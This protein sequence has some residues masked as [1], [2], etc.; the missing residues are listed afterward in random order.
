MQFKHPELLYALFLLLIPIIVHL[1]Q[2]RKFKKIEFTNVAFLKEA[3]LQTRKSSRIKK[4]LI[5]SIRL[6][7]LTTLVIAFAQPY[8]SNSDAFNVEKETVVYLDN[9]FSM[10]AKG[11]QGELLKRAVQDLINNIPSEETF[12]LITNDDT[13]KN[14]T[15]EAIKNDLLKLEYSSTKLNHEAALLKSQALFSKKEGV[16][17]NL[18]FISDFQEDASELSANS[19]Q[20]SNIHFVQLVTAETNNIS[21][22]SV[23]ISSTSPTSITLNV[24]LSNSGSPLENLPVSLFNRETLIAKTSVAINETAETSFSIPSN[25]AIDGQISIEDSNL[26]F[27]NSLYFN[28]NR[29]AKI[30][31]LSIN[32]A[33]DSFL[34][35]IYTSSEFDYLATSKNQLD[36][37][38]LE[39]QNLIVLNELENIPTALSITLTQFLKLGGSLL[40]IP[41]SSLNKDSYNVL[42]SPYGCEIIEEITT[43]KLV[44]NI[45][46]AHPLYNK[47]VFE[48]QVNNFQYPRTNKYY[49]LRSSRFSNTL[50]FEDGNAFLTSYKHV[51][52]FTS[53]LNN[54]NSNFKNSP[55]IVPTLYNIGRNSYKIP[56]IYY[57]IG[58]ANTFEVEAQMKQDAVLSLNKGAISIIP[59]QQY[60]NSKV[61]ISSIE[62]PSKAGTYAV[63][64]NKD[65]IL[66]VS[67]NYSRNESKL[68]YKNLSQISNASVN[69]SVVAVLDAIKSDTKVNEL[70]KWFVI[71]ALVLLI[72]EM[73]ILKFFK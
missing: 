73:L 22:D 52:L 68:V 57:N 10:Q 15:I 51:Y 56:E 14:T 17:K 16:L 8:I 54:D 11:N 64:N 71:F 9:S 31:V 34:K 65:S 41:S 40:I 27:D 39:Q 62:E 20:L 43:T 1:F 24:K 44:T 69:N 5:L 33:E 66:N 53:A 13:Y 49:S 48:K 6:L 50:S 30:K 32:E 45:N 25:E 19:S 55:L 60:F 37:N 2:L 38:I 3:K 47:G 26:Q 23:F 28:I 61:R 63:L 4:W 70:W 42:I 12:S 72:T 29:T 36:F 46:Y 35:K 7:L 21:L 59:R 58:E 18:I 67:Y